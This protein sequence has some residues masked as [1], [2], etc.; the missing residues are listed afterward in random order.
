MIARCKNVTTS[1]ISRIIRSIL[2]SA[3]ITDKLIHRILHD[4]DLV[5]KRSFALILLTIVIRIVVDGVDESLYSFLKSIQPTLSRGGNTVIKNARPDGGVTSA[6][7]RVK[8]TTIRLSTR[9]R[10]PVCS[11]RITKKIVG[12][13]INGIR[14][15]IMTSCSLIRPI[16]SCSIVR[17]STHRIII[18]VRM[19]VI[20]STTIIIIGV[21]L[22]TPR[23]ITISV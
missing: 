6:V 21:C 18:P 10:R 13:S 9:S 16:T 14:Q 23:I 19:K 22:T 1:C 11:Y 5:S 3:I 8:P 4:S 15:I 2:Y 12:S 7:R 17:S 20:V